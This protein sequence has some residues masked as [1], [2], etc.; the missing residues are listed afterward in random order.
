MQAT[1]VEVILHS[2]KYCKPGEA[3]QDDSWL[4]LRGGISERHRYTGYI[5]GYPE[6]EVPIA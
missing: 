1:A 6:S 3:V 2:L 5:L 4:F